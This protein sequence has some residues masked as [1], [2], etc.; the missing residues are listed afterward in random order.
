M[1]K[2]LCAVLVLWAVPAAKAAPAVPVA[3]GTWGKALMAIQS[4]VREQLDSRRE[5]KVQDLESRIRNLSSQVQWHS[6]NARSLRARVDNLR[7]RA[8]ARQR[9][10][11]HNDPWFS[12]DMFRLRMD[13]DSHSRDAES[14]ASQARSIELEAVADPKLGP[15]A[16]E[17]ENAAS[18]AEWETS[19]LAQGARFAYFDFVRAGESMSASQIQWAADRSHYA[20][21]ALHGTA[22]N[23]VQKV[24]RPPEAP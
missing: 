11:G 17:L 12:N 22:R 4:G 23:I 5:A 20:T 7:W 15:A 2:L 3:E 9:R 18:Q 6:Y 8:Q 1:T 10:P 14:L 19:W 24:N 16:R 13:V 21:Q